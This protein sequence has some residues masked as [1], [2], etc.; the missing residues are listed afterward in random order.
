[1]V[2][3]VISAEVGVVVVTGFGMVQKLEHQLLALDMAL[4][5]LVRVSC[6]RQV[7][8]LRLKLMRTGEL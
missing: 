3:V 8:A 7:D 2:V 1:M 5:M 6:S 4:T